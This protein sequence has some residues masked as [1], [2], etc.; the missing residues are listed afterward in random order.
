M[1]ASGY[2][3][4]AEIPVLVVRDIVARALAEDLGGRLLG[5]GPEH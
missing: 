1:H 4:A 5:T 2:M 3:T